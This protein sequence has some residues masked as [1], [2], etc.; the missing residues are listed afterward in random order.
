[1]SSKQDLDLSEKSNEKRIAESTY[2]STGTGVFLGLWKPGQVLSTNIPKQALEKS[3]LTNEDIKSLLVLIMASLAARFW[4]ISDP[5]SVVY[6]EAIQIKRINNYM[7]GRFFYDFNPPLASQFYMFVAHFFGYTGKFNGF[8]SYVG[9]SFPFI[10]LRS[11]A[12]F[13]GICSIVTCFMT[14]K[15]TGASRITCLLSG[16]FVCFE[17][18]FALEHR[19]IF[20]TPLSLTLFSF[21][22]YLW[23]LLELRHPLSLKWH[24]TAIAL[25]IVLGLKISTESNSIYSLYWII[26]ASIYQLWWSVGKQYEKRPLYKVFMNLLLRFIY[27]LFVPYLVYNVAIGV[28]LRLTP[29]SGE[30]DSSVSGP[31]QNSLY[32]T[33]G[34][35]VVKSV[36]IGSFVTLRHLKTNVYLHSHDA[37][38]PQGSFQQQVTGYGFRDSNN[39]WMVENITDNSQN[40][41]NQLK[42]DTYV[43]LRHLQTLKRLH[44][45]KKSPPVTNA[46]WQFEVTAYGAEGYPGDLNDLWKIETVDISKTL[47]SKVNIHAIDSIFRLRHLVLGCYL[48]TH[49]RKLPDYG[50]DQ[51]EITCAYNANPERTYW[52]FETNYHPRHSEDAPSV[53]YDVLSFP[54]KM[55]EYKDLMEKVKVLSLEDHSG[56]D[57]APWKLPF[58]VSGTP[59]YR[60]HH[61][62]VILFGNAVV[63][64]LAIVGVV[65]YVLFKIYTLL[66][67]QAHWRSFDSVIG[68]KEFD[69]HAGGFMMM[70]I[71]HYLPL[72]FEE[73]ELTIVDYLPCLYCTILL[74]A[75]VWD[76][77]SACVRRKYVLAGLSFLLITSTISVYV[78]FSP[79]VYGASMTQNSCKELEVL[80]TWDF[81]CNYYFETKDMA[82]GYDK[83][84]S[85]EIEYRHVNPP[86]DERIAATL[87]STALQSNPTDVIIKQRGYTQDE[88]NLAV[89]NFQNATKMDKTVREKLLYIEQQKQLI[90]GINEKIRKK[91]IAAGYIDEKEEKKN[92]QGEEATETINMQNVS[93]I[94]ADWLRI[95][96]P[97]SVNFTGQVYNEMSQIEKE[98]MEKQGQ[99]HSGDKTDEDD[100]EIEPVENAS[101]SPMIL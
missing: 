65:A 34:S 20:S 64:Y 24:V 100:S 68:I 67:V 46:D 88:I 52:Y 1:M 78:L 99:A 21:T 93:K 95:T 73:K 35:T 49:P 11:V 94:Q 14:L 89:E 92:Q 50:F 45:H 28:H 51:Q 62:Q 86:A 10:E 96:D 3:C 58:L 97:P 70:Y 91:K 37:Y 69:H 74:L 25:G 80:P 6:E 48:L 53:S 13:L 83:L 8:G 85:D 38:Y 29:A 82:Y 4:N 2:V 61:R 56:Y 59:I 57:S 23:K 30:G 31:F 60:N 54:D 79:I 26:A 81:G 43:K 9:H 47:E 33:P 19:F 15:L 72:F 77:F 39:Y 22:I 17:S 63:W 16:I 84:H 101:K 27:L 76:F 66:A 87:A 98:L 75:K 12:A 18:S 44:S 32:G 71:F 36:G 5:S 7:H 90:R 55:E 41:F 42:N 40:E